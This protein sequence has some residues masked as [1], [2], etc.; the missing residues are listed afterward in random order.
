MK[1]NQ[2]QFRSIFQKAKA[3][4]PQLSS[5]DI[6]LTFN[7]GWFFT[8]QAKINFTSLLKKERKYT[9]NVNTRKENLLSKLSEDDILAW[10][11][12]ELAHIIDYETMSNS[13]ILIFIIR[14]IID[15]KFRFS[16][17]RRINAYTCNNGF[18]KELLAAWK[19]FCIMDGVN[20]RYQNYI[21]RNYSPRWE[22][23][24]V[25]AELDG[26]NENMYKSFTQA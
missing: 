8:M 11:G 17:E 6:N 9:I 5:T 19:K 3:R 13:K 14:Y 2:E 10:F 18:A 1:L 12:H 24:K 21:I 16:V 20:K 25:I 7:K 23:I 4:Y 22:D 26:I 15:L